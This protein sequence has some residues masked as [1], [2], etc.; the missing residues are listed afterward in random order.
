M[1]LMYRRL[2]SVCMATSLLHRPVLAFEMKASKAMSV[3]MAE[4]PGARASVL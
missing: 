3:L 2:P 4:G 1:A